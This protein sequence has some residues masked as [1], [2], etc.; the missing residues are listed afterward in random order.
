MTTLHP[1][2]T[3]KTIRDAYL[4]YL[5]TAFPLDDAALRKGYWEALE[6]PEMLVKGPMLE[7]SPPFATG[8]SIAQ[9]VADGVLHSE[10]QHLCSDALPWDRPLYLHQDQAITHVVQNGRNAVVAT[11]TGSGKTEAFL[12]PILHHLLTESTQGSLGQPGVRALLLYP[13]NALANDQ[14]KR[15]RHMLKQIPAITFGRYTGE[16]EDKL[17]YATDRFHLQFP[18]EEI[19][20]NELICRQQLRDTPPHL[21]LTNYSMLEYL[22]LRPE[23]HSFF[24]GVP[25]SH[26]RF[27]VLD[28][29]HTYD[30]ASGM[31]V[32]MLLRRLKDRIVQSQ[33]GRLRCLATS[34]TLGNGRKDYPAT[35]KFAEQLFGEPF[36]WQEDDAQCQDVIAATRESAGTLDVAWGKGAPQL[37][38]ALQRVLENSIPEDPNLGEVCA[39]AAQEYV[40]TAI[41]QAAHAHL[42]QQTQS[43]QALECFIYAILRGDAR[44]L[45]LHAALQNEPC[46]L[47]AIAPDIFPDSADPQADLVTLV[48]L[49]ARAR[50]DAESVALLPARYHLFARALEGVF[51]CLNA[52][53]HANQAPYVSLSRFEVCPELGCGGAVIELAAC[54]RCGAAYLFGKSRESS[55]S[56]SD[57]E[58]EATIALAFKQV[59]G[60]HT[61]SDHEDRYYL[62]ANQHSTSQDDDEDEAVVGQTEEASIATDTYL[63]CAQCGTIAKEDRFLCP[64]GTSANTRQIELLSVK[65]NTE[66]HH[67]LNCGGRNNVG[68]MILR[69]STG[70]DAPVSVLATVLYQ[71]LPRSTRQDA[72]E[73]PGEGRKLLIFS[74]SRQDAAFFAPYLEHTYERILHR[75]LILKTLQDDPIGCTGE[76]RLQDCIERLL[77]TGESLGLFLNLSSRDERQKKVTTWLMQELVALDRRNSLAGVGLLAFRLVCPPRWQPPEVLQMAPWNLS[78]NEI[79]TIYALLVETLRQ[80]GVTTYPIPGLEKNEAFAPRNKAFYIRESQSVVSAGMLS[81]L[82]SRGTNRRVGMLD[83]VLQHQQPSMSSAERKEHVHS[84]L[85]GIWRTLTEAA[86]PWADYLVRENLGK[87]GVCYRL[88]YRIWELVPLLDADIFQCDRCHTLTPLNLLNRC[89]ATRCKGSLQPYRVPVSVADDHY[90]YLYQHFNPIAL[91]AEEHTAQWTNVQAG[92]V[93]QEF[94]QD[95]INILSCSTTFELGVDVGDLQAVFMRNMPPTTANYVQRAGRAGRRVD[96]AAFALTYAQRR[97]HDLTYYADPRRMVAGRITPPHIMLTNSKIIRRHVQAVLIAA[98]LREQA[99]SNPPHTYKNLGDFFETEGQ[100]NTG[101]DALRTYA[102]KHPLDVLE[103]LQRIVPSDPTVQAALDIAHWGWLNTGEQDGMLDL[104]EYVDHE[105]VHDIREYEELETTASQAKD[106]IAANRFQRVIRTIRTRNLLGFW[107]SRN[108]LPKYGF[109]TDVVEMKTD[110][111]QDPVASEVQLQRDLRIAIAEYA[112]GSEVVAAKRIWTCGGIYKQYQKDWQIYNYAIC[113]ECSRFVKAPENLPP[114]CPCGAPLTAPSRMSFIIPEF[115]FIASRDNVRPSGEARPQRSYASRVYFAEYGAAPLGAQEPNVPEFHRVPQLSKSHMEVTCRYSRFGKL[116]LVNEGKNKRGFRVCHECGFAEAAPEPTSRGKGKPKEHK[117]PRSGK[118]CGA[119]IRSHH[120]GHEFLTDVVELQIR[121]SDTPNPSSLMWR[122]LVYALLEGASQSLG[123]RRDDLDGTLYFYRRHESPSIVLFDNVPGGAGHAQRIA[124]AL[125]AVFAQ[126]YQQVAHDCCGPETSCYECLRNYRN[127]I[128][129]NV[130]QRGI[131]QEFLRPW[132]N[133]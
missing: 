11:G 120:L 88:N 131:V 108:L 126:A 123:I 118:P 63:F 92:K 86:T 56:E 116:A 81:W 36:A 17:N 78:R 25:A 70:Q 52:K 102:Q 91:T 114:T 65:E 97:S 38:H 22:L 129:H 18:G 73:L 54:V 35:V 80:Q 130:L 2:T 7:S 68:A 109:P 99:K 8:R 55:G 76:L 59:A 21:L 41:F 34:A 87:Y 50:P 119:A 133:L 101:T 111:I 66:P 26:W 20:P 62:L 90:R 39:S 100:A 47:Q 46:F 48:D 84:A 14:L 115:G 124:E 104:L 51:V 44:V 57:P 103:A 125:P 9:L 43:R 69:F 98:F 79:W 16:T 64:C 58:D 72:D 42:H 30:G 29:A 105:V 10:F 89:Q 1:I 71:Q 27:I 31:E 45:A 93:Q 107:A 75:H 15:L 128:Y 77:H 53:N 82:P 32:A 49:A 24:D 74:D 95:K 3:T 110:H 67:C 127:Q 113:E 106:H 13:M 6:Q 117:N 12:L 85:R 28:E 23:D 40:P 61:G 96:S 4:R 112:P 60:I 83:E 94:I 5:K 132:S 19:L 122:S 33:P 121:G 37:Y